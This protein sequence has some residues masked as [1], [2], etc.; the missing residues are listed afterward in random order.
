[1][2][3]AIIQE[4]YD[5]DIIPRSLIDL[6]NSYY[7]E[8]GYEIEDKG[9]EEEEWQEVKKKCKGTRN[10]YLSNSSTM[11]QTRNAR[12]MVYFRKRTP[13][14]RPSYLQRKIEIEKEIANGTQ[15]N[16]EQSKGFS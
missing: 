15:Q 13:K 9:N 11:R 3:Q 5:N 4:A 8:L 1:M 2:Y 6:A 14:R 16:I 12:K 7:N 10:Q